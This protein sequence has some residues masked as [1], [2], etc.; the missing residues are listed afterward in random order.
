[1]T[2]LLNVQETGKQKYINSICED[3]M[4]CYDKQQINF[5]DLIFF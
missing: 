2:K 1:M 5:L 4:K 3:K